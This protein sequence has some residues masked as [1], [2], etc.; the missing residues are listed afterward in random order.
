MTEQLAWVPNAGPQRLFLACPHYE[1]LYEGSRGCGK[2]DA[3]LMDFVQHVGIGYGEAWRGIL[4]RQT[5]P[6]LDDIIDRSA[7]W[8][9]KIFPDAKYHLQSHVW[10]FKTGEKLFLR[11]ME[12][13]KDYWD[14]HGKE[15]TWIAW[16]EIANWPTPDCYELMKSCLRSSKPG[17][18]RKY[19][20]TGNPL[21]P[22]HGWVKARFVDPGLPL[23]P[24]SNGDGTFRV[25]V[26]GLIDENKPLFKNDPQYVKMIENLTDANRIKAWRYGE[27]DVVAGGFFDDVWDPRVHILKPFKIPESWTLRRSLDWGSA[28]PSSVGFWAISDGTPVEGGRVFPRGSFIRTGELYTVATNP[29]GTVQ[30]NVG[31]KLPN[32]TLGERIAELSKDQTFTGCVADPSIFTKMGREESI[33]DDIVAGARKAG[34]NLRMIGANTNRVAGWQRMREMLA[35]AALAHPEDPGL[36][37]FETCRQWLRTVPGLVH[38]ETKYDDI[39]TELEDHAAD[40]TRYAVMSTE[41]RAKT[42]VRAAW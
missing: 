13:S 6:Q 23:H 31:T 32:R 37:V 8:F 41:R 35:A 30:P 29:D 40:E 16:D 34:H 38:H 25:R 33:Y 21:G 3:L 27:W 17:L 10:K 7:S 2:T 22:G 39:D 18:P 14:Y 42:T 20:A 12:R 36:W 9:T 24:V 4:F 19:R 26:H 15:F 28:K 5:Y 1:V 11:Y